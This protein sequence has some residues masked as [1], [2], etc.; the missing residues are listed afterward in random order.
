MFQVFFL[1]KKKYSQQNKSLNSNV[2]AFDIQTA[3]SFF[4]KHFFLKK[5]SKHN[6]IKITKLKKKSKVTDFSANQ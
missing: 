3:P 4:G 5:T 2:Q 1:K 6:R